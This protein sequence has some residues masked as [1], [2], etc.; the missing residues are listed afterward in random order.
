MGLGETMLM[1]EITK[2]Q[3]RNIKVSVNLSTYIEHISIG[4]QYTRTSYE[5]MLLVELLVYLPA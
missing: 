3:D 1:V 2:I 5:N 4:I